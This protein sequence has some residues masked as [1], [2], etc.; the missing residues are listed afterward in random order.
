[1]TS[2]FCKAHRVTATFRNVSAVGLIDFVSG[3][4][5]P[6]YPG[7]HRSRPMASAVARAYNGCLRVEPPAEVRGRSPTEAEALLVFGRSMEAANL[8]TFLKF[9]KAKNCLIFA[10]NHVWPRNWEG[11][12]GAKLGA[13]PPGPGLKQPL[14]L[15][16]FVDGLRLHIRPIWYHRHN[17]Y[18]C[19]I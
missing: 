7:G 19:F 12:A 9:G 10:K 6:Q 4:S 1:M 15:V 11:G 18:V 5:S 13:V 17:H 2:T 8:P 3:G 14:L 16:T